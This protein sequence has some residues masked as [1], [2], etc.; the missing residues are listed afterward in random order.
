MALEVALVASV[1]VASAERRGRAAEAAVTRAMSTR[2][3]FRMMNCGNESLSGGQRVLYSRRKESAGK[4][5]AGKEST[6]KIE[7]A[8]GLLPTRSHTFEMAFMDDVATN[9]LVMDVVKSHLDLDDLVR[10][11][12]CNSTLRAVVSPSATIEAW[13]RNVV[14]NIIKTIANFALHLHTGCAIRED[15]RVSKYPP[16]VNPLYDP[17]AYHLP[18]EAD[19]ARTTGAI[20]DFMDLVNRNVTMNQTCVSRSIVYTWPAQQ[21]VPD[22]TVKMTYRTVWVHPIT[23]DEAKPVVIGRDFLLYERSLRLYRHATGEKYPGYREFLDPKHTDPSIAL[24]PLIEATMR[25]DTWR[26]AHEGQKGWHWHHLAM[27]PRPDSPFDHA[28]VVAISK[29]LKIV[30]P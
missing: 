8:I 24:K 26:R 11:A 21:F 28:L 23:G 4:E 25:I 18:N 12:A 6:G 7:R 17:L 30:A 13:T 10:L 15:A 16:I 1:A 9:P 27:R 29:E 3:A 19:E 14:R 2:T 5:S 22:I 20:G